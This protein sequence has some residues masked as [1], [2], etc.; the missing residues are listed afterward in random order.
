MITIPCKLNPY[1]LAKQSREFSG[2]IFLS[3]MQRLNDVYLQDNGSL[4][5]IELKFEYDSENVCVVKGRFDVKLELPCQRCLQKIAFDLSD[6]FILSPYGLD[7]K[8]GKMK[9]DQVILDVDN[10][11]VNQ[12]IEDEILLCLPYFP[13]HQNNNYCQIN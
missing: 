3:S 11:D 9:Y 10:I 13:T 12:M 5:H 7:Q 6:S 8:M 1:R 2:S 4:V